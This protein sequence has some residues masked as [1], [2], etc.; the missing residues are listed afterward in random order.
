MKKYIFLAFAFVSFLS[1]SRDE[2]KSETPENGCNI[3]TAKTQNYQF[4]DVIISMS[5]FDVNFNRFFFEYD[6]QRRINKI[7]GGLVGSPPGDLG[8]FYLS[9]KASDEI[10]YSGNTVSVKVSANMTIRPYDKEFVIENDRIISQKVTSKYPFQTSDPVTYLYEYS[11]NQILEK[12][13]SRLTKTITVENGNLS[14]V[15]KW[16]YSLDGNINGKTEI[17]YSDY[18]N[19]ENLLKGKFFINGAFYSA[20][21]NN[22]YNKIDSKTYDLLNGAYVFNGNYFNTTYDPASTSNYFEKNCN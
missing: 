17:I 5:G 9:N 18:D 14:K 2:D 7:T 15:I 8:G 13:N 16:R 12:V 19:Q 20:F 3:V 10:T 4:D 6:S 1:C 22:I 11:G 21:S